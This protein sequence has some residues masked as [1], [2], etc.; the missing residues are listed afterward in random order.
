VGLRIP[1]WLPLIGSVVCVLAL[2]FQ[3]LP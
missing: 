3:A 2:L 1:R